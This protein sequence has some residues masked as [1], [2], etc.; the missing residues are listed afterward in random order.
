MGDV[1]E[2]PRAG[3]AHDFGRVVV[4]GVHVAQRGLQD[5]HGLGQGVEH[6]RDQQPPEAVDVDLPA[7]PPVHQ[8]VAPQ[9]EDQ[10]QALHQRRRQQRQH[11][12]QPHDRLAAHA[13]AVQAIGDGESQ[14]DAD[15][16][17]RGAH[18]E[19][20]DGGGQDAAGGEHFGIVA[21]PDRTVLF[22]EAAPRHGGQGVQEEQRQARQRNRHAGPQQ[23]PVGRPGGAPGR[24]RPRRAR[25][26]RAHRQALR[27]PLIR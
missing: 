21:Q 7:R 12:R 6:V 4:A 10:P 11:Q 1:E 27:A 15:G 13:T 8:P 23:H 16:G 22:H 25:V 20:V 3:G 26:Q 9:D 24:R 2:L 17:G 5:Q 14:Q 18:R 19:A